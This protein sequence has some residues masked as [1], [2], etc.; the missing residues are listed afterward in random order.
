MR[1]ATRSQQPGPLC[2]N[3]MPFHR[4]IVNHVERPLAF[5]LGRPSTYHMI[6]QFISATMTSQPE[7]NDDCRQSVVL[8]VVIEQTTGTDLTALCDTDNF[9]AMS[10]AFRRSR[11]Y[12]RTLSRRP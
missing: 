4:R 2:G 10:P 5:L 3:K 9:A 8:V 11:S 6:N 12:V 1:E 7:A